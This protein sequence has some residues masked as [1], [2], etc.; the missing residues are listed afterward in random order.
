MRVRHEEL[1]LDILVTSGE[2]GRMAQ[3]HEVLLIPVSRGIPYSHR[4][5][6]VHLKTKVEE[7]V[8]DILRGDKLILLGYPSVWL[9]QSLDGGFIY[10]TNYI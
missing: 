7:F 10:D 3:A 2:Q 4:L 8:G 1:E 5:V 9:I 6:F